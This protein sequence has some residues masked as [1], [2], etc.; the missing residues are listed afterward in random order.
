MNYKIIFFVPIT[1]AEVVKSALFK[2]N[3]GKIGAY[4][5]CSF[6]SI[7]VGQYRPLKG[8]NPFLGSE[9]VT[10]KVDELRVEMVCSSENLKEAVEALKTSHPY[11]MPAFDVIKLEEITFH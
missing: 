3:A 5:S 8:S 10:E 4:D 1:H 7:G 2:A 11:E 9:L 6:E